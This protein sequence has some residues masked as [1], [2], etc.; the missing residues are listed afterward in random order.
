[1][2]KKGRTVVILIRGQPVPALLH[3]CRDSRDVFLGL[4]RLRFDIR[5]YVNGEGDPKYWGKMFAGVSV[6]ER[7]DRSPLDG[8]S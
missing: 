7:V 1:M 8:A 3:A 5:G 6:F 2:L 4:I